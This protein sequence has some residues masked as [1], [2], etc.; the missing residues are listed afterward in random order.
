MVTSFPKRKVPERTVDIKE[1]EK[2]T[3]KEVIKTG[4]G[5]ILWLR[6]YKKVKHFLYNKPL[7]QINL[8]FSIA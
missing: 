1:L 8:N 2:F 7:K 6:G 5:K 4:H 3:P